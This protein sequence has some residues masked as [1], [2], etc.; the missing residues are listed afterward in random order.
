MGAHVNR[1]GTYKNEIYIKG[2]VGSMYGAEGD[3]GI[4]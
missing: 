4:Q 1:F 2:R 3:G